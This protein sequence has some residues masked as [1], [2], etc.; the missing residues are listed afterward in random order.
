MSHPVVQQRKG[1][2]LK[3]LLGLCI[4]ILAF[5]SISWLA[6]SSLSDLSYALREEA[7]HKKKLIYLNEVMT[8]LSMAESSIRTFTLTHDADYLVPYQNAV[9]SIEEKILLL[10]ELTRSELQKKRT[11]T[12]EILINRKYSVFNELLNLREDDEVENILSQIMLELERKEREAASM[13]EKTKI[14][15]LKEV[16][17]PKKTIREHMEN[18]AETIEDFAEETRRQQAELLKKNQTIREKE[19]ELTRMDAEIMRNIRR[20]MN[21][22]EKY[23]SENAKLREARSIALAKRTGM[24]ITFITVFGFLLLVLMTYVII[25]YLTNAARLNEEMRKARDK[26]ES[27]ARAKE[28][29]LAT[30]SHEIRTPMNAILGFSEQLEKT[31]LNSSQKKFIETIKHSTEYL[32][33][34]VNDILDHAKLES[35]K[36]LFENMGFRPA[37]VIRSVVDLFRNIA[38]EK[39]IELICHIPNDLP[40]VLI[41]DP[42]RLKQILFNTIGNAIKFTDAG[43]VEVVVIATEHPE[44]GIMLNIEISDTGIGIPKDKIDKVF[45]G[46]YQTDL[47]TTRKYGGTGLGLSITKKLVELQGGHLTIDSIEGTGTR[48]VITLYYPKGSE[49]HMV[50]EPV[51]LPPDPSIFLKGLRVLIVDDEEYNRFLLESILKRWNVNY[52]SC[53]NANQALDALRNELFDLILMDVR[54]PQ[55]SGLELT[56]IIRTTF[57]GEKAEIPIIA[58]TAA[59]TA[60]DIKKCKGAGMNDFLSKPFREVELFYCICSVLKIEPSKKDSHPASIPGAPTSEKEMLAESYFDLS[61]LERLSNGDQ[62]FV[63]DMLHTFIKN[64]REGIQKMHKALHAEDWETIGMTAHRL[65]APCRH[66]GMRHIVVRLKEIENNVRNNTRLSQIPELLQQTEKDLQ[67]I[68]HAM[69]ERIG[70]KSR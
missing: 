64:T 51:S 10:H 49:Q 70:N 43:K 24:V 34:I 33:K 3:V 6:F 57:P 16:F 35:G 47:S 40:S 53:E 36:F 62:T 26:A 45:E 12:L 29:F 27:L 15:K 32:L 66:L 20:L 50:K 30:M 9:S 22:M 28:D 8:D 5:I 2:R 56:R 37:L 21:D 14:L 63:S 13:Q 1:I 54:M 39:N 52:R 67:S 25:T 46:F 58:L 68:F 61:D 69:E 7:R 48:L 38:Q 17:R 60:E 42:Y 65:A 44:K 4:A 41:G 59:S 19:L 11:D 23:E 31:Q 18:V 55:V